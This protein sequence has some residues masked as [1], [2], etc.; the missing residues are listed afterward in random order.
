MNGTEGL[1]PSIVEDCALC[2]DSPRP[3]SLALSRSLS[4]SASLSF[5]LLLSVVK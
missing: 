4:L 1:M 5:G 2:V 3:S